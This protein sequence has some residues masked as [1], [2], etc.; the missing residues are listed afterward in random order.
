MTTQ[1]DNGIVAATDPSSARTQ[2]AALRDGGP[3]AII[4]A[5]R[6]V[7]PKLAARA[8]EAFVEQL[9]LALD[10]STAAAPSEIREV[11]ALPIAA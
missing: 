4:D 10:A 9:L 1:T 7:A 3:D 5:A 2:V 6:A 8:A 11:A